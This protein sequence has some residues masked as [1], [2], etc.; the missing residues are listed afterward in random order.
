MTQPTRETVN[1]ASE[2]IDHLAGSG[3]TPSFAK[4]YSH[5]TRIR[6]N[7]A[8]LRNWRENEASNRLSDTKSGLTTPFIKKDNLVICDH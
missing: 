8:G 5:Y 6:E 2:L 7:Q 3:L 4:L 1:L